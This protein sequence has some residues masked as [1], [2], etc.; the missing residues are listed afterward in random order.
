MNTH[1][2]KSKPHFEALKI[3]TN[4]KIGH[5]ILNRPERLNAL[6]ATVLKELV[7]AAQWFDT[8]REI[9]VVI[10][11]GAGHVFSAGADLKDP[12]FADAERGI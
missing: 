12:I 7:K 5:L 2:T 9:R 10:I 11:K 1:H 3:Q 8:Q 6:G 4:G